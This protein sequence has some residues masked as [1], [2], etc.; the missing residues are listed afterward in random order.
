MPKTQ[1]KPATAPEFH[2]EPL[3]IQQLNC[4]D[5]L[6]TGQSE[7]QIASILSIDRGSIAKWKQIPLFVAELNIKRKGLWAETHEIL[8]NLALEAA[9]KLQGKV[10]ALDNKEL[11]A[12]VRMAATLGEPAGETDASTVAVHMVCER[13][14]QEG[15]RKSSIDSLLIDVDKNP[16]YEQRQRELLEELE[17][18]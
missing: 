11:I 3:T 7:R 4:I 12:L 5:L 1:P 10:E 8:R 6:I 16:R 14:I 13:L 2:P 17:E 9:R 15:V 18:N